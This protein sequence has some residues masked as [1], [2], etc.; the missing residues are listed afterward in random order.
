MNAKFSSRYSAGALAGTIATLFHTATMFALRPWL[1]HERTR[2]LP[3][4][5]I[6]S[7]AADR[8]DVRTARAGRGLRVATTATHFGFGAAAGAAYPVI[9]ERTRCPPV[10]TG[11]GFGLAVW[12][13]SYLGWIPALR[14][15]PPATHDPAS[16][17]IMMILAH[18]AWGASLG[19]AYD[20]MRSSRRNGG[21]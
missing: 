20:R 19:L 12:A 17:T 14:L 1:P 10:A 18:V 13:A 11:V 3:P 16:R 8:A 21:A 6:T 15:L 7:V 9:A 4:A 2:A 5:Q